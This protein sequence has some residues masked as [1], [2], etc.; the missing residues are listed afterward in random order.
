MIAQII[1]ENLGVELTT[2][3]EQL[4]VKYA[5]YL[6]EENKKYNLTSI[7]DINEI[8]I[9][10]FLDSLLI[11]NSVD[12]DNIKTMC[13][14]GTGAGFPGVPI[15]ILYPHLKLTL[16]DSVKKKTVFLTNLVELLN[17]DDVVIINDRIEN[18]N[19]KYN[20]Y[21]ELVTARAFSSLVVLLELGIPLLKVDGIMISMKASN[22]LNDVEEAS[23]ALK[24]LKSQ[25]VK[26]D[27]MKLPNNYGLRN[28]IV[29]RK[30]QI[31]KGYPRSFNLI[32]NKPLK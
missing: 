16:V 29:I 8:Y 15:K 6:I 30:K 14:I 17:L 27:Q 25:I 2:Y 32:K 23:G 3:Q 5:N 31:V 21:F 18:L 12:F 11:I 4:F 22:Y 9:K 1:K 20:N 7:T 28:Q 26:V 19:N 13:D 10:H 24:I